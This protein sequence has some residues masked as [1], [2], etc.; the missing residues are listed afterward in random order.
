MTSDLQQLSKA[1]SEDLPEEV[2]KRRLETILREK[3][4]EITATLEK[5]EVF[6]DAKS[7]LRISAA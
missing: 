5:G 2:L 3:A 7:G 1:L 6:E 4:E